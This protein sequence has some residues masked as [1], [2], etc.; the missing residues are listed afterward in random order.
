MSPPCSDLRWTPSRPG[1]TILVARSIS[2]PS[3]RRAQTDPPDERPP[4]TRKVLGRAHPNVQSKLT[5]RPVAAVRLH[6]LCTHRVIASLHGWEAS[7]L[8][9]VRREEVWFR[10]AIRLRIPSLCIILRLTILRAF[11]T[12][13][14]W[15]M[16]GIGLPRE[17]KLGSNLRGP[18]GQRHMLPRIA[19]P[20]DCPATAR[21]RLPLATKMLLSPSCRTQ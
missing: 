12:A 15:R 5:P 7:G 21:M 18:Q 11:L 1:R 2:T 9:G 8:H 6:K 17:I 10:S 3:R 19:P 20:N 14:R 13:F 16:V 4:R